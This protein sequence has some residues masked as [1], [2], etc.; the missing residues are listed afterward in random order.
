MLDTAP[1]LLCGGD[2][3]AAVPLLDA[4][5]AAPELA[6]GVRTLRRRGASWTGPPRAIAMRLAA[7]LRPR[8]GRDEIRGFDSRAGTVTARN[9]GQTVVDAGRVGDTFD[10]DGTIV[11]QKI[12]S[13]DFHW[14][15]LARAFEGATRRPA[16]VNVYAG[17]PGAPG[18]EWHRDPH[19][20]L[21]LQLAGSKK[22]AVG[23][24]A[25]VTD[26]SLMPGDML[27]LD[28]GV[29]HRAT[30]SA[31]GSIHASLGLLHWMR[32][33]MAVPVIDRRPLAPPVPAC[34]LSTEERGAA[35]L[36]W[37][38]LRDLPP[39]VAGGE[40]LRPDLLALIHSARG[41]SFLDVG[42]F[43]RALD[44]A[45][46]AMIGEG[47]CPPSLRQRLGAR[48]TPARGPADLL[49]PLNP[50]DM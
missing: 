21:V 3:R 43:R 49:A 20:V 37:R 45:E 44:P 14:H 35:L 15:R 11:F 6:N 40:H 46:A 28:R 5:A 8:P 32:D 7:V 16:Q 26:I 36:G 24:G 38:P 2:A 17:A 33:T 25:D 48:I 10:S 9:L 41:E 12:D 42:G 18:L 31:T 27:W 50:G 34:P 23:D 4:I 19:D 22:F 29:R 1:R 13:L 39:E 30:N 47:R